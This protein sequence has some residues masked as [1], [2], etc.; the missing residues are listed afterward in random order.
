MSDDTVDTRELRERLASVLRR[1]ERLRVLCPDED[2][3]DLDLSARYARQAQIIVEDLALDAP[4]SAHT[5]HRMQQIV[6]IGTKGR[7]AFRQFALSHPEFG[8][9]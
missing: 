6:R 5:L 2:T 9:L 4:R 3:A 7:A 1:T 8:V